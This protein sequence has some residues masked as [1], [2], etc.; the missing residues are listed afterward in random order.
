MVIILFITG[1]I[2][3]MFGVLDS[4]NT[5]IPGLTVFRLFI[6]LFVAGLLIDFV[7]ALVKGQ[8]L[9]RRVGDQIVGSYLEK[10]FKT[11]DIDRS[12]RSEKIYNFYKNSGTDYMKRRKF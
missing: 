2:A 10:G 11:K 1:C 6:G 7:I 12:I 8:Q 3:W 9:E 4:V 5:I